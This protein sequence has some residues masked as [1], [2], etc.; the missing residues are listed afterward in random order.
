VKIFFDQSGGI[1]TKAQSYMPYRY[2]LERQDYSDYA[3]GRVFYARPGFPAFPV[4]LAGEILL[5]CLALREK[6]G[7]SGPCQLYDPCCGGATHLAALGFLY[8]ESISGIIASDIDPEAI[9]LAERNLSLLTLQG[10]DRRISELEQLQAE[11]GKVSHEAALES[12]L[13]LRHHI[14]SRRPKTQVDIHLFQADA[15]QPQALLSGM[16]DRRAGILLADVPYGQLSSWKGSGNP[17]EASLLPG[18]LMLEAMRGILVN[19]AVVAIASDKSQKFAHP[20]YQQVGKMRQG[21]RQ[22]VFLI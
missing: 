4:R 18:E 2:V 11:F 15:T 21:K 1:T 14:E 7:A 9:S 8:G 19:G 17:V 6:N 10:I 22:V 12:A 16:Q 13:R 20:A 3:G 5:R